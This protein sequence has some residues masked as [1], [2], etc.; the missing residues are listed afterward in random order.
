LIA[1]LSFYAKLR[2]CTYYSHD[3]EIK[4]K[5][6]VHAGIWYQYYNYDLNSQQIS[7]V[8]VN[9]ARGLYVQ[10]QCNR[11]S[12]FCTLKINSGGLFISEFLIS[13]I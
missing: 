11:H 5:F 6:A 10:C 7:T 4:N 9:A 8:F 13:L 1:S 2:I 12:T 3:Q